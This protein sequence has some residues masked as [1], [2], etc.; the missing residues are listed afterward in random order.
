MLYVDFFHR[1]KTYFGNHSCSDFPFF[2]LER[3]DLDIFAVCLS[4]PTLGEMNVNLTQSDWQKY[5][6]FNAEGR[7]REFLAVRELLTF[8]DLTIYPLCYLDS[9]KP[10]LDGVEIEIS[11]SHSNDFAGIAFSQHS[12]GFDIQEY[13]PKTARVFGRIA[14]SKEQLLLTTY[15]QKKLLWSIK[16]ACFKVDGLGLITDFELYAWEEST[17]SAY[18]T[19][20]RGRRYVVHWNFYRDSCFVWAFKKDD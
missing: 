1:I 11:I 16:E 2:L 7:K 9:G 15:C 3:Q 5:Q 10:F 6:S 19:D 18:L 17:H 13:T 4:P 8:L 20:L 12:V 14:T